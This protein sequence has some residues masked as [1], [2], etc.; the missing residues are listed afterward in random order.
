[1]KAKNEIGNKYGRLTVLSYAGKN[2]YRFY[3]WLCRCDCGNITAVTGNC[4]RTGHIKSCG[5]SSHKDE[6]GNIYGRLTVIQYSGI[7]KKSAHWLCKCECGNQIVVSGVNLRRGNTQSCGCFNRES[8]SKRLKDQ[9]E[10][11]P[12]EGRIKTD[13][14]YISVFMPYHPYATKKGYVPEHRLVYESAVA[15]VLQPGE[16]IHHKNGILDDNRIENLMYFPDQSAHVK[17][18]FESKRSA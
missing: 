16:V 12:Y 9:H 7:R 2:K 13:R 18:H 10:Q 11:H 4:L 17:F 3:L 8:A 5:C 6:I 15:R 1:M 14:G